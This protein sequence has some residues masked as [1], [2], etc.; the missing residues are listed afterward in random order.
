MEHRTLSEAAADRIHEMII[1]GEL[2]PGSA[3]RLVDLSRRLGT[4]VM[5]VREGLRKLENLGLVEI[6]AHR[7]AWVRD[8]DLEDFRDTTATRLT[9]ESI[10]VREAATRF[11]SDDAEHSSAALGELVSTIERGDAIGA[12]GA[13][14]AFHFA[15]YAACGSKWLPRAIEPVW[16]NSERY[17]FGTHFTADHLE[18]TR[19]EHQRILDACIAHDADAAAAAFSEHLLTAAGRIETTLLARE[20]VGV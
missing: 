9:L 11:T 10:A 17:R 12:R 20:G 18:T 1:T 7:G 15:L 16:R 3:I 4:S 6:F 19:Q 5:P 2:A 14:T 13:H 8:V